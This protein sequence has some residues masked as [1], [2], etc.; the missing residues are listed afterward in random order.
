MPCSHSK[1]DSRSP[2]TNYPCRLY[3]PPTHDKIFYHHPSHCPSS[4]LQQVFFKNLRAKPTLE[5]TSPA[6][7]I[8]DC[9]ITLPQV[10]SLQPHPQ[11]GS[12]WWDILIPYCHYQDTKELLMEHSA[13][14][15]PVNPL[16]LPNPSLFPSVSFQNLEIY[17]T[18]FQWSHLSGS[19]KNFLFSNTQLPHTPKNQKGQQEP[20]G[21]SPKSKDK[22][23]TPAPRIAIIPKAKENMI[24]ERD[25]S[26][27]INVKSQKLILALKIQEIKDTIKRPNLRLTGIEEGEETQ[28]K[29]PQSIFKKIM[30]KSCLT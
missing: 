27:K 6:K 20:R 15:P 21:K 12:M 8:E 16:R 4:Y 29:G 13:F 19:Q 14:I 11:T 25:I 2:T 9:Q 5:E 17:S 24:E 28:I 23:R 7:Q 22:T 30:K 26:I 1:L 3:P 10:Q 18:F